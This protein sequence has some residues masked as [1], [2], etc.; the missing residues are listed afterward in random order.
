LDDLIHVAFTLADG[1]QVNTKVKVRH[2]REKLLGAEFR[3][4]L[5]GPLLDNLSR[6]VFQRREEDVLAQGRV[7]VAKDAGSAAGEACAELVLVSSSQE[8]QER[9]AGL[10]GGALPPLRRVA[11]TIQSVRDLGPS[12]K[13]LVLLH[14]DSATWEARK[15]LRT[16]AEA[17]PPALPRV[18]VGTGLE[19]SV[20]FELGNE[21]KAAWT[22]PLQDG[23]GTL[24]QRLLQGIYRKHFPG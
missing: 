18:V 2:V 14:A 4:L 24:F 22:Y 8:L 19:T 12:G 1:I 13:R 5:E 16:L 10:L 6:W 7:A 9:L 20:L 23:P 3:P 21:V 15:R 17:L 11:P